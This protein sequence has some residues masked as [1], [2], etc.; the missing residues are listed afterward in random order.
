VVVEPTADQTTQSTTARARGG[1]VSF[2][3]VKNAASAPGVTISRITTSS[4]ST[5][6]RDGT[7][8]RVRFDVRRLIVRGDGGSRLI[9]VRRAIL[10]RGGALR[11]RVKIHTPDGGTST[12]TLTLRGGRLGRNLLDPRTYAR[13][14]RLARAFAA[15]Q[16]ELRALT[17]Q[18]G[19]L[20]G[21]RVRVGG[22]SITRSHDGRRVRAVVL[23]VRVRIKVGTASPS[24]TDAEQASIFSSAITDFARI[25][26]AAA[27]L[28]AQTIKGTIGIVRT[29]AHAGA[30]LVGAFAS[31]LR[32]ERPELTVD[33]LVW[34]RRH[35]VVQTTITC[36]ATVDVK[37][38]LVGRAIGDARVHRLATAQSA[39]RAGAA[40]RVRFRLRKANS[41]LVRRHRYTAVWVQLAPGQ[42]EAVLQQPTPRLRADR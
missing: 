24:G 1:V 41:R 5:G 10:T 9:D 15:I 3:R 38:F 20:P 13:S 32:P 29:T 7:S 34:R 12:A 2:T 17:S 16:P 39:C 19:A 30:S 14:R 27:Q 18:T 35:T 33:S 22:T 40:S 28:S 25:S 4:D 8:A 36:S 42:P 21:L 6:T 37:L 31:L 11:M 26:S 23:P